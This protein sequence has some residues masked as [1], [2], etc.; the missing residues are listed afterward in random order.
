MNTLPAQILCPACG[1]PITPKPDTEGYKCDYCHAV[2][3]PGEEEDSV[4]VSTAPANSSSSLE[5]PICRQPLV[6][7]A[8]ARIPVQFCSECRGFLLPMN[9]LPSLIE[10]RKADVCK[11]AV[12]TA[13]DHA[14]LQRSVQCPQC[15]RRMDTHFYAGPGNVILDSCSSC[16]LIWLDRGELARI[17]N[18][19]DEGDNTA[20][21]W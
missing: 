5:C 21:D 14:D 2:F 10:A 7:A 8:I 17:A 13:P 19:P 11:P 20:S 4:V 6:A 12:Q 1:A 9:A 16:F 18:A 15:H 3:Y